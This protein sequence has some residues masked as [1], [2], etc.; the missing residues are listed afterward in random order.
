MI[1]TRRGPAAR[2]HDGAR[3][4]HV[5][6]VQ[7]IRE[8]VRA[9]PLSVHRRFRLPYRQEDAHDAHAHQD[10]D[11]TQDALDRHR[12]GREAAAR[13]AY[14]QALRPIREDYDRAAHLNAK[15]LAKFSTPTGSTADVWRRVEMRL[16]AGAAFDQIVA[17]ADVLTLQALREWAPTYPAVH[18]GDPTAAPV[19]GDRLDRATLARYAAITEDADMTAALAEAPTLA[20]LAVTLADAEAEAQGAPGAGGLEAAV[21]AAMVAQALGSTIPLVASPTEHRTAPA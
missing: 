1:L 5:P 11:F 16:G 6:R 8:V 4:G 17:T 7:A 19:L 2:H 12:Q 18:G 21:A 3:D 9:P 13:T 15:A 14:A 20:G 10:P